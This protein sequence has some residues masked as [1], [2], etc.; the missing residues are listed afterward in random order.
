VSAGEAAEA[1]TGELSGEFLTAKEPT[2]YRAGPS[3]DNWFRAAVCTLYIP[4]PN[5]DNFI[6]TTYKTINT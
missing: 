4:N 3:H 2:I 6:S 5:P 1:Q